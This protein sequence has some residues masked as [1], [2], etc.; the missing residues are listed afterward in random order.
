LHFY[1]LCKENKIKPLIGIKVTVQ[2][3]KKQY[4]ITVY[5]QNSTG[6]KE[7]MKKVFGGFESPENR[8]FPLEEILTLKK[9]CLLVFLVHNLRDI[10]YFSQQP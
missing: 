3:G 7:L 9:N 1:Q 10:Y 2:D 6:Y 8:I 5:P 4:S